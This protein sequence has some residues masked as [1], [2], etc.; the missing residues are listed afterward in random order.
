MREKSVKV[1][2]GNF[3]AMGVGFRNNGLLHKWDFSP[4]GHFLDSWNNHLLLVRLVA[5]QPVF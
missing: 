3:G 4:M 1:R 5:Q 2:F